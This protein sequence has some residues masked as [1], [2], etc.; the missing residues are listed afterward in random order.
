MTIPGISYYSSFLITAEIGGVGRF[1]SE[2]KLVSYAGLDPTARQSGD[3]ELRGGVS[4]AGSAPHPWILIQCDNVAI[5]YD[6]Y[7]KQFYRR[8]E[9]RKNHQIAIESTARKLLA[10]IYYKLSREEAW[11]PPE[12]AS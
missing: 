7:L 5:R 11:N 10:S 12:V 1:S 9:L 2:K 4:K 3:R 6:A 8:L